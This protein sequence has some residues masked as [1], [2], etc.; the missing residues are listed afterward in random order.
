MLIQFAIASQA[1]RMGG[2]SLR[3]KR[4]LSMA[5]TLLLFLL[6]ANDIWHWGFFL[7]YNGYLIG[8]TLVGIY[9]TL[10]Y[11][12]PSLEDMHYAAVKS[13]AVSRTPGRAVFLASLLAP[14]AIA[15]LPYF[16]E[17]WTRG[18]GWQQA[19][20][21]RLSLRI[22]IGTAGSAAAWYFLKRIWCSR[23]DS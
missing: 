21:S 2:I 14:I 4:L 8:A 6:I 22:V 13:G 3:S 7:G 17:V 10:A 11:V 12:G 16:W 20:W 1:L 18:V 23:S 9:L 15:V 5:W 19:D